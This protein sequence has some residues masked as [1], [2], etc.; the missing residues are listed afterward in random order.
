VSGGD[1]TRV[2]TFAASAMLA[3]VY[4][5][6]E[7]WSL[8]E[9]EASRVIANNSL[10][11]LMDDP[12]QVFLANSGEAI[13]QFYSNAN[14][15]TYE[16]VELVATGLGI[17]KYDLNDQL[18]HAFEPGDLR[19]KAWIDSANVLGT[20]Y[21]YPAKLRSITP[22][23]S[24]YTTILRLGEQFLI[25]AEA[26]AQLEKIGDAQDDL[27]AIRHRANL[28][29]TTAGDKASLLLAIEHERQVELFCEWGH[30]WLDLKRTG[31]ADAVLGAEKSAG[32]QSTDVLFPI[33]QSAINTNKSLHQN[34]GY[35]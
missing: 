29:P 11:N 26:R 9:T 2:N 8:A 32:W 7:Q 15:L 28:L 22:N 16:A 25:R 23:N 24:E 6:T 19:K 13:W 34:D 27:D 10:Y 35:H 12:S 30:R 3:R 5:Y 18:Y 1:R 4:L 17:P 20:W 14:G 33:P 21:T 31:R